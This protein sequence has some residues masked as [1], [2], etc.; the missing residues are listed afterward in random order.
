MAWLLITDDSVVRWRGTARVWQVMP[1]GPKTPGVNMV[2]MLAHYNSL[3]GSV[4]MHND[5]LLRQ[6]RMLPEDVLR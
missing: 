1:R 3:C 5:L 6:Q 4:D 2:A